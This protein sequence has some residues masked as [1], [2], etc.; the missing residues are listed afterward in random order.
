MRLTHLPLTGDSPLGVGLQARG[1]RN[2]EH[3]LVLA[4]AT[5]P[6]QIPM[7]QE[8]LR[9]TLPD[10]A[11]VGVT[12][13]G[14][15]AD[16]RIH[17]DIP[18]LVFLEF[19]RATVRIT[20]VDRQEQ[21][22]DFQLGRA[23][24]EAIVARGRPQTALLW[25]SGLQCNADAVLAG[26]GS[27][28]GPCPVFGAMAADALRYER[29]A[30]FSADRVLECGAA[31]VT[32]HGEGLRVV[33]H[34][35]LD[36]APLGRPLRVTAA[37]DNRLQALDGVCAVSVLERYLG[38][39][40]A[41]RFVRLTS[42]FPLIVQRRRRAVARRCVGVD[43]DGALRY[44]GSFTQGEAVRFGL[45]NLNQAL[46]SVH[47][48]QTLLAEADPEAILVLPSAAR[49]RLLRA[50]AEL[51]TL[52]YKNIAPSAGLFNYGLFFCEKGRR[53]FSN[54]L[55][56]VLGLS[57]APAP[58]GGTAHEA[59]GQDAEAQKGSTTQIELG[60][61]CQLALTASRDLEHL[62]RSL[63]QL[64]TTDPL[65]ELYNRRKLQALIEHELAR[66]RRYGTPAALIMMDLDDFKDI[67]DRYGHDVGDMILRSV[68]NAIQEGLRVTDA[69]GRW[70][71]EEFMVLCPGSR[72]A[73]AERLG[74]RIR[75]LVEC[76]HRDTGNEITLSVGVT[77]ITPA[78]D[79]GSL[80]H[81][82][83]CALYEAKRAGKNT[84]RSLPPADG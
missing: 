39:G 30:V 46:E 19:E 68:A 60:A 18:V 22:G 78:D 79:L 48:G 35:S 70:G 55:L 12:T 67:N 16:G 63:E 29:T 10:A 36:W 26:L 69:I 34:H 27:V 51:E 5:D 40:V 7:L 44:S 58:G 77:E 2:S 61:L 71:G 54:N 80:V 17:D 84:V 45:G 65:T 31:V 28:G 13:A 41:D 38:K 47:K 33:S 14:A 32:L 24:G 73:E 8:T 59:H 52:G 23:L 43:E 72:L 74:E 83:D 81:R 3:L 1:I 4:L 75:R 53:E 76:A 15:I 66:T 57:E 50:C 20:W 49:R 64:A 62:N 11:W 37:E 21:G 9:A 82:A 56:T 6:A 25:I 42:Q